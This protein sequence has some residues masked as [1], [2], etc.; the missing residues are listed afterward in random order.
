MH[1]VFP[2]CILLFR[3]SHMHTDTHTHKST[4]CGG[5]RYILLFVL[6]QRDNIWGPFLIISPASTLNNW[7]QEF[8]R[9]V[10]KFKVRMHKAETPS[11]KHVRRNPWHPR[12]CRPHLRTER[13]K[14]VWDESL[15]GSIV[16]PHCVKNRPLCVFLNVKTQHL[17]ITS[18]IGNAYM[19][20]HTHTATATC[21]ILCCAQHSTMPV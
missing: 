20:T 3:R 4:C 7:H 8:T 18:A 14:P 19:H 2:R 6:A 21:M 11:I 10:P 17:S 13:M 16:L 1:G 5:C 15:G 12:L 9:F